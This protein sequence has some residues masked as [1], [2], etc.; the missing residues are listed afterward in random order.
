MTPRDPDVKWDGYP[1]FELDISNRFRPSRDRFGKQSQ[2]DC[3][4]DSESVSCLIIIVAKK[5]NNASNIYSSFDRPRTGAVRW[6][7]ILDILPNK[8]TPITP[9]KIDISFAHCSF[10]WIFAICIS[11]IIIFSFFVKLIFCVDL[12][13]CFLNWNLFLIWIFCPKSFYWR[14]R[15]LLGGSLCSNMTPSIV[16]LDI[17][18]WLFRF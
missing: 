10:S 3:S 12:D 6:W 16:N 9:N 11:L 7:R 2:R 18:L 15:W 17:P 8:M 14:L 4:F 13:F 1:A 5:N